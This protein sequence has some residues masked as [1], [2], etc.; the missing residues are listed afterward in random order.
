MTQSYIEYGGFA[1]EGGGFSIRNPRTPRPWL[2][3]LWNEQYLAILDQFGSGTGLRQDREGRRVNLV[4]DRAVYIIE[5]EAGCWWLASGHPAGPALDS[6]ECIHEPGVTAVR[7]VA[8]G[9]AC[10]WSVCVACDEPAELWQIIVRNESN[11]TRRIRIIPAF[12]TSIEGA[13]EGT[14]PAAHAFFDSKLQAITGSNVV[15]FGSWY[16]HETH[17][18][19][20]DGCFMCDQPLA[21]YDC[22][23][24][25]FTGVYGGLAA[26]EAVTTLTGCGNSVSEFEKIIFALDVEIVLEPGESRTVQAVA[27]AQHSREHIKL[28]RERFLFPGGVAAEQQRVRIAARNG[29]GALTIETPDQELNRFFNIWLK[30]QLQFNSTWA[31]VYF[32]G[33]RDIC[34]DTA[35]LAAFDYEAAAERFRNVLRHQHVS[36]YAPRAWCQGEL[37]NQDYSD[38]PVWITFTAY[39]LV[40]E[41]GL[42]ACLKE[43]VPFWEG[44]AATVYEHARRSLEYLWNDRGC[45]GLS[46]I[47]SGDWNDVMNYVG[48][49]GQ[50]ESVWLS[51]ALLLALRQLAELAEFAGED[52]AVLLRA[53]AAELQ[54]AITRHGWDGEWYLRGYTDEGLPVGSATCDEAKCFL[55][56]QT[57]AVISGCCDEKRKQQVMAV[58]DRRLETPLGTK[59]I[60][61]PFRT[62]RQD[63]GFVSAIRPGEN[64]N[65][66]I[67]VHANTFKIVA[68]CLS[69]RAEEAWNTVGKIVPF[70]NIRPFGGGEPFVIPNS[71]YG[72]DAGYR[73][74]EAG[75]GWITGSAGWLVTVIVQYMFGLY[76]TLEGLLIRP[77]LPADW[78]D[79]TVKR[80]FRGAEYS[81]RFKREG[82]G[83]EVQS[84]TVNGA[85]HAGT[86]LPCHPG[87]RYQV[88]VEIGCRN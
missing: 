75:S 52:D 8:H 54:Q 29:L 50:G 41:S 74:G 32:N 58:V 80:S 70:S 4:A 34:Q 82:R 36:G 86:L 40:M 68:D 25:K 31:R 30:H 17:G 73:A 28:L 35:N 78:K 10:E 67:Y 64:V 56:T 11:K 37:I 23:K 57:W 14:V 24:R 18:R 51:M 15:R 61:E 5:P 79:C 6:Y 84:I 71:Y 26:P 77:C 27:A 63:I 59:T 45:H 87:M 62:F 43:I 38:S 20:E 13:H 55:N 22:C 39:A 81:V 19:T 9:V 42:N 3:Y 1:G 65:A 21:A 48:A 2:N 16:S 76:P 53:R 69:G 60:D 33:F 88:D 85:E 7:T 49:A 72:P 44:E 83:N 12:T 47:H 66:G 46:K